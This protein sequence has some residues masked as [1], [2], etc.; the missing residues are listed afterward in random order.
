MIKT[1]RHTKTQRTGRRKNW[2]QKL[3]VF[4]INVLLLV[5]WL[6]A[7]GVYVATLNDIT[8]KG[9]KTKKIEQ[10]LMDLTSG[11][12]NLNLSLSDKQSMEM[13]VEKA[14]SMGM[15]EAESVKYVNMPF[16]AVAKK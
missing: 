16:A 15:V 13:V 11:N 3:S 12:Q 1:K 10:Q 9:Y 5:L 14:K 2:W 7:C 6:V 4:K 8:A